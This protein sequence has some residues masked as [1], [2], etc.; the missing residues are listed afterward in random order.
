MH[1]PIVLRVETVKTFFI[2]V[3]CG[4]NGPDFLQKF[5][6]LEGFGPKRHIFTENPKVRKRYYSW[7]Q[8]EPLVYSKPH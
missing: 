7:N 1:K 4:Q 8:T 2:L 3:N 6:F 5:S